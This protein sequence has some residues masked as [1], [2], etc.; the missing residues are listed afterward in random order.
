MARKPSSQTLLVVEVFLSA[1]SEWRYGYDIANTVGMKSGTLYPI[2]ARLTDRG[3]LQTRWVD[4]ELEGRP[5]RHMYQLTSGGL[6]WAR[7]ASKSTVPSRRVVE[8]L[9]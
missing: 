4:S 3:H 2:L 8:G 6:A 5:R 1:P 7:T 9:A